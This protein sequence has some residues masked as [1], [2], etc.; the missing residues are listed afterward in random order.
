M[1]NVYWRASEASETLSMEARDIYICIHTSVSNT[2]ACVT[3]EIEMLR[4]GRL[5]SLSGRSS[6][7]SSLQ[8]SPLHIYRLFQLLQRMC[9]A[10]ASSMRGTNQYWFIINKY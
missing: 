9:P 1:F 4:N 5:S 3:I 2:H 7:R 10:Y 6:G 8:S